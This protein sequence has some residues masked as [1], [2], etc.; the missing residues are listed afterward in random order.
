MILEEGAAYGNLYGTSYERYYAGGEPE[1]LTELDRDLPIVIGS[2]GF[3]L[4]NP[5]QLIIGN[6]MPD[7]TAGLRNTLSYKNLSLSFL[8]DTRVGIDQY[9]QY[10]NFYSAFGQR[11]YSLDRNAVVVFDGVD[12]S[13]NPNTTPVWLG[14]GTGPDEAN[15]GAGFWRNYHRGVS[16]NFVQ[17][18]SFVKLRNISLEYSLPL[19]LLRKTPFTA[20]RPSVSANNIILWTPWASFDPESFSAGAGGNATAFTGLGYPGVSSYYLTLNLSL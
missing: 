20:L 6:A 10:D 4:R 16:E 7:W 8:I 3:P 15:Y 17:D 12:E 9:S 19:S 18:A 1:N 5:D 13:G 11:A 2:N 14:Q